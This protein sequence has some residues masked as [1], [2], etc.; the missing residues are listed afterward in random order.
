MPFTYEE[1]MRLRVARARRRRMSELC[2]MMPG[3]SRDAVVE[4]LDALVRFGDTR[5]A[6]K[7]VNDVLTLQGAG[8]PLVNGREAWRAVPLANRATLAPFHG[9][10]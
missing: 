6:Q 1:M 8:V 2:E 7:H 4:A 10:R 3:H 9:D 5:A